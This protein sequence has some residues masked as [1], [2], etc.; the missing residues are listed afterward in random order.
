V[1]LHRPSLLRQQ[2]FID[3]QWQDADSKNLIE[4]RNPADG[5]V[6]A[7]VP[8]MGDVE[9]RRAI[10][11]ASAAFKSW[12]ATTADERSD[13]L[14]AWYQLIL[15]NADDLAV[16]MTAEQ[17]K[18]ISEAKGEVAYGAS[19]L[20][21]YAEEAR[22]VYG[23]TIPAQAAD[24]RI[25]VLRQPVGVCATITPWN[26][27][28]AMITRKAAPALAAGCTL[29]SRPASLTPLSALALAALAEEAGFPAGVVNFVTGDSSA[30]GGELTS[31]AEVRKLSFTGSTPVGRKLMAQ[32]ASTVKNLS[33]ELGGN[34]P[35]IVFDDADLDAAVEGVMVSKFRN[36]GQTCVCANR[37]YVQSSIIDEFSKRLAQRI[38]E[39]KVGPGDQDGVEQ[40]PL[41]NQDAVDKVTEHIEDAKNK[42]AQVLVGGQ[43]DSQ[44]GLF[45]APTLLT[46]C[47]SEMLIASEET[48]GPVAPLFPFEDEEDALRLANATEVGLAGYFYSR[49]MARIMRMAE[50]MEVGMVG[51]NSGLVSNAAAP[52]GGVKQSGI[53]REGGRQ[54]IGEYLEE[55]YI[56]LAG[57]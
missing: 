15:D 55:K 47:S 42:G 18:P 8:N 13:L 7:N 53:G 48:F 45:F 52:F 1:H 10:S 19:F 9:T 46:D 12:K 37:I 26:F 25:L 6:F 17:G 41:I 3:G 28:I 16:I 51:V 50:G 30:I 57:I 43:P 36:T 29:V 56:L 40:G 49:D 4:V 38:S 54:G 21:W 2:A 33:M 35:F 24:Q 31:N 39:L 34:A 23:E 27:P 14:L 5:E 32:C 20:K 22:R 11:A 44:G